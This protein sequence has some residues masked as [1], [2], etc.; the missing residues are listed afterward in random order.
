MKSTA[1][2]APGAILRCTTIDGFRTLCVYIY[3]ALGLHGTAVEL[4]RRIEVA[5]AEGRV[6]QLTIAEVP[7][8]PLCKLW[9]VVA[10]GS[11]EAVR[12][13]ERS[14]GMFHNEDVLNEMHAFKG[15]QMRLRG[16]QKVAIVKMAVQMDEDDSR[17]D[18]FDED[19][20]PR[21]MLAW[22]SETDCGGMAC[23][24]ERIYE[25]LIK[26][27]NFNF[28]LQYCA[29]SQARV[30]TYQYLLVVLIYILLS[31]YNLF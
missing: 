20:R 7:E 23:E 18:D 2:T 10:R 1:E 28:E 29:V 30:T 24:V 21:M 3:N 12:F 25:K 16:L 4:A 26:I 17:E 8:V 5:L 6:E 14:G 9:C 19:S 27:L 13:V 15:D 31:F 11:D 22:V